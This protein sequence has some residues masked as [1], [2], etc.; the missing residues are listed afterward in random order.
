MEQTCG[1]R[2]QR[3]SILALF[4]VTMLWGCGFIFVAYTLRAGMS[5]AAVLLGRF[6]LATLIIGVVF[7]RQIKREYKK[8][9]WKGGLVIGAIL[10]VAF[11]F[12]TMA[13]QYTTPA[14]NAFLTAL[15]VV[16]VPFFWWAITKSRPSGVMFLACVISFVGAGI[17]ALDFSVGF[18]INTG[19]ALTLVCAALFAAQIVATGMLATSMHPTVLV[20]FQFL[21]AAVFSLFFFLATD[22]DFTIFLQREAM[23]GIG[24]L[25][26]FCTCICYFLQTVAQR[27]LSSAKAG[28]IMATESLFGA[29]FSVLAGYDEPSVRMVVGGVVMFASVLLPELWVAARERRTP[30]E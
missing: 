10:F 26:V 16:I 9:Q 8:G 18:A 2:N 29:L 14:N 13:L 17:L 4:V 24:F 7:G 23:I 6:V 15:Y 20:F 1:K 25:T 12:Q 21:V 30:V 11:Y 27:H 19:D 5:P 28:I 22:R 3:L